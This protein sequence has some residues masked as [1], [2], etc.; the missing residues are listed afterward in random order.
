MTTAQLVFNSANPAT[1]KFETGYVAMPSNLAYGAGR[2]VT[3]RM[4]F[5]RVLPA[6]ASAVVGYYSAD[7]YGVVGRETQI[8]ITAQGGAHPHAAVIDSAPAG[9]TIANDPM[10]R[11]N[12]LVLKFT[13][14]ANGTY[15]IK[16]RLYDAEARLITYSWTFTVSD[17]W[18]VVV[19]PTGNNTTGTGTK[20]NPWLTIDH[21]FANTTGGKTL[22]LENGT[23]TSSMGRN[24]SSTGINSILAWNQG[25]ATIGWS[26]N[27]ETAPSI[28]YYMNGSNILIQGINFTDPPTGVPSPRI[29]SAGS[30]VSYVSMDNCGFDVN[31]RAGTANTDN[32][33]LFFMGAPNTH[34]IAQT[35]CEMFDFVGFANGWSLFDFYGTSKA[36][37]A[38]NRVYNQITAN[39]SYGVAWP[40]G[41]GNNG[42]DILYNDFDCQQGGGVFDIYLGNDAGGGSFPNNFTGNIHVAF[43]NIKTTGNSGIWIARA[44]QTGVRLPIWSDRNTVSGGAYLIFNR[45]YSVTFYSDSDVIQSTIS[46]SDPH[47]VVVR[48]SSGGTYNPLSYMASLTAAV[49][50]YNCQASSGVVDANN[51]LT[52]AYASNRGFRGHEVIRA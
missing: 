47:R 31:S 17:S 14:T 39:P 2:F 12:Y 44:D 32:M 13:P 18:Y 3:Q 45:S 33:S 6:P 34:H 21:A 50:N 26:G 43:N 49:T 24:L 42:I 52:G 10:D 22:L 8:R 41:V 35:R 11:E 4:P 23:Y 30:A 51:I 19:S 28:C 46:S 48:D 9:A 5:E 15:P 37:V 29:F 16:V 38:C 7:Y 36:V 25:G 1:G 27:V 20:A 40:K